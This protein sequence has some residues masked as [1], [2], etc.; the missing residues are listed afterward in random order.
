MIL[1]QRIPQLTEEM[2]TATLQAAA[3]ARRAQPTGVSR[4]TD[5]LVARLHELG[6]R[7]HFERRAA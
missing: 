6:Y 7:V 2:R 1:A 5:D 3:A 4:L